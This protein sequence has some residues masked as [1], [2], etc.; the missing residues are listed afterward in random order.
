MS[1]T[2]IVANYLKKYMVIMNKRV[3]LWVIYQ[4]KYFVDVIKI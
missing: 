4:R 1:F 2:R 3:Y